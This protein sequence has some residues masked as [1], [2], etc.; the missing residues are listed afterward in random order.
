MAMAIPV[1]TPEHYTRFT[2]ATMLSLQSHESDSAA[3]L[4]SRTKSVRRV[5]ELLE[6]YVCI[7]L[8]IGAN[9]HTQNS[10]TSS[11][12]ALRVERLAAAERGALVV[13]TGL[14]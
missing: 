5:V 14:Q 6:K 1:S 9:K 7:F 11:S 2:A 4:V 8:T 3:K 13:S 12:N 10:I